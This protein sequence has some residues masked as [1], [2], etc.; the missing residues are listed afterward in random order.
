MNLNQN[1]FSHTYYS[2][3]YCWF[4]KYVKIFPYGLGY[5]SLMIAPSLAEINAVKKLLE[6]GAEVNVKDN[7]SKLILEN[8]LMLWI[9]NGGDEKDGY[10]NIVRLLLDHGADVNQ[11]NKYG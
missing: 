9:H 7:D 1:Y 8:S 3:N 6:N 11:K 5:T 10:N 2:I 4:K